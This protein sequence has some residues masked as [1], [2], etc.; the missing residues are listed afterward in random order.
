MGRRFATVKAVE[1]RRQGTL[2][3][4]ARVSGCQQ[5]EVRTAVCIVIVVEYLISCNHRLV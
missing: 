3:D 5:D 2:W 4:S 1:G